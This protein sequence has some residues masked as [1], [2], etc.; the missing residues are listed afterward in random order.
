[1]SAS[2]REMNMGDTEEWAV[3]KGPGTTRDTRRA[4]TCTPHAQ[5]LRLPAVTAFSGIL[6]DA[7][8]N[9]CQPLSSCGYASA[10]SGY[11][12]NQGRLATWPVAA[13]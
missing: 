13:S 10:I 3:S 8:A 5:H 7:S 11:T 1:M 4:I 9:Y 6:A 2:I 12:V